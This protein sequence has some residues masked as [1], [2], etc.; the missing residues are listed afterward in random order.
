MTEER[1]GGFGIEI[2]GKKVKS[3]VCRYIDCATIYGYL[4]VEC[5]Q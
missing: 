3:Y 2:C 4:K 5:D 1:N